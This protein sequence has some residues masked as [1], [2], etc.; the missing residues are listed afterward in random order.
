MLLLANPAHRCPVQ[1]VDR[2]LEAAAACGDAELMVRAVSVAAR[3]V[4]CSPG[5]LERQRDVAWAALWQALAEADLQF[6][7]RD[8]AGGHQGLGTECVS[9]S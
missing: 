2:V 3:V 9:L 1:D 6:F 5:W 8:A 4:A 7:D